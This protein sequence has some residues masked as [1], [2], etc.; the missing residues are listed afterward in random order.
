M[1]CV[2]RVQCGSVYLAIE[3]R[4]LVFSLYN[5]NIFVCC[6]INIIM[7]KILFVMLMAVAEFSV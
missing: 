6:I 3:T 2:Q 4:T 5:N 1:A 7:M